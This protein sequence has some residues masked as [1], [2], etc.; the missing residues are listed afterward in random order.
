MAGIHLI[1][2]ETDITADSSNQNARSDVGTPLPVIGAHASIFLG[3]KTTLGAK[4][5]LFRT[6][7]DSYEGSLNFGSI[8][9]QRQL[10]KNVSIGLGY[11]FYGVK[12]SSR[13][14]GV[15][16]RIDVRHQGPV[17]FFTVGF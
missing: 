12:L 2:L 17:A 15:N 10:G 3:E 6:D 11:N 14:S 4:L 1:D 8:D 5:Q 16:G 9:L 7:F 13:D